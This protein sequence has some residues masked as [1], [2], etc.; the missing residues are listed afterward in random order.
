MNETVLLLGDSIRLSY[1]PVAAAI[2]A[3]LGS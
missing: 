3:Q 1:Q 2:R